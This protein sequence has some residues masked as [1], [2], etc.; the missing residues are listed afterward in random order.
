MCLC[1]LIQLSPAAV[2]VENSGKF[3]VGSLPIMAIWSRRKDSFSK[4]ESE[5]SAAKQDIHYTQLASVESLGQVRY[6]VKHFA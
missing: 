3:S 5:R 6:Y 2:G 4:E 1:S